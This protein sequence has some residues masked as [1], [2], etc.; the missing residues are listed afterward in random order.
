MAN[1]F[2]SSTP[3][4]S[5]P[6]QRRI[7]PVWFPIGGVLLILVVAALFAVLASGR[8]RHHYDQNSV[9]AKEAPSRPGATLPD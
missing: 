2:T 3:T 4:R 5:T 8:A 9:P 6:T 1:D 7:D